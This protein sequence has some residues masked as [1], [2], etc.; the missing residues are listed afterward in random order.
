MTHDVKHAALTALFCFALTLTAT[1]QI[2]CVR[3]LAGAETPPP[4]TCQEDESSYTL[5]NGILAARISKESGDMTSL[6]YKGV[7]LLSDK[8]GHPGA[9]WSHDTTGGVQT[10]TKVTID[11]NA[12]GHSRAEVSVKG[13]SGG[14][15]MG[16]GPGAGPEGNMPVD[17]EIRYSL[18]RGESGVYT[19]CIFEH[20]PEYGAAAMCEARY[21]AKLVPAFDWMSASANHNKKY[22]PNLGD[23]YI[24]TAVQSANPAFGWSS[25]TKNMGFYFINPSME[26]MSCGPT[27]AELLCHGEATV[28]N[29]WRS[30]HYGGSVL[31]V[32]EGEYWTKVIG[33]FMLYV[34][35]GSDPQAMW[36]DAKA[37]AARESAKWPYK[38]VSGVDYPQSGQRATVKGR[39]VLTDPQAPSAELPNLWVGL[40]YPAYDSLNISS[41]TPAK[42]RKIDWWLDAKH[43]EFWVRGDENGN[44]A[45]PNVRGGTY[46]LHAFADGVLGEYAKADVM[47]KPGKPLDLG[48][49]E[50]KP[51]RHGKQL[52]DIGIANRTGAEF[53]NG[54]KYYD[55][56]APL[57]YTDLFPGDVHYIVWSSDY[58]KDWYF[59][60]V[61]HSEDP[62]AVARPFFGVSGTGRATPWSIEFLMD[63]APKGTATLRL[64]ICGNQAKSIGVVVNGWHI[65]ATIDDLAVDGAITRHG[66]QAIWQE[67]DVAFDASMLRQGHNTLT[68]VVPAGSPNAGVIYDYVRLELDETAQR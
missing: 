3:E 63:H 55:P 47:V 8:N 5:A 23:K 24:Y 44:F 27:K 38:W 52:W 62:N 20:K 60:Q 37:Q 50:W 41:T 12:N 40:A 54:D 2:A 21:C 33:P 10:V 67:K 14:K 64:A 45:I 51:V 58:H 66:I 68:L 61:P 19:Y 59:E 28:L 42:P 34:N 48:R 32:T 4:V 36:D 6:L 11:P 53:M 17:I 35:S 18:G 49:L 29:Y 30:S 7:E 16:H 26:Y 43:Y 56:D 65:V 1:S 13:I 22:V 15:L 9:Y 25:T 46:T 57:I 31:E 39:L